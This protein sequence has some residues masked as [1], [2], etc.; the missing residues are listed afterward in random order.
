MMAYRCRKPLPECNVLVT[1]ESRDNEKKRV[2][3][4]VLQPLMANLTSKPKMRTPRKVLLSA[5]NH[6]SQKRVEKFQNSSDSSRET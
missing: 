3:G 6:D 2:E 4:L 1:N 5:F